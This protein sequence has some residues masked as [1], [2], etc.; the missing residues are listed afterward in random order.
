MLFFFPFGILWIFIFLF[1]GMRVLS[2]FFRDS[3]RD[4]FLGE[5]HSFR[6]MF[7]RR[8]SQGG[9]RD[10]F[11]SDYRIGG[12]KRVDYQI[13]RLA[14][15]LK[16]K[17]TISDIV[18]HTGLGISEAEKTMNQLVDGMRVKMEVDAR[19]IVVYEFPEI[20]ARYEQDW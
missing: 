2:S 18:I 11:N 20:I 6:N 19:G 13:F 9:L 16:G 5:S 8:R 10:L 15:K 17:L 14:S 12:P 1:L 3:R 4:G 7:I